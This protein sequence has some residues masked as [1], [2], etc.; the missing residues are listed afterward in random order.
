MAKMLLHFHLQII[1]ILLQF[2]QLL[3][4]DDKSCGLGVSSNYG[5]DDSLASISNYGNVI[6]MAAQGVNIYSTY[7]SSYATLSGTR[8][9]TP[10]VTGSVTLYLSLHPDAL[11]LMYQ[12]QSKILEQVQQLY[13]MD[14]VKDILPVIKTHLPK[15]CFM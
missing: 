14:K 8:M 6:D 1:P 4:R 11:L 9:A 7:K 3:D 12:I 2:Q 10:H 13:V 15:D 5:R